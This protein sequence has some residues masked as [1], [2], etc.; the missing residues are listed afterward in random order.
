[1]AVKFDKLKLLTSFPSWMF[2]TQSLG[3]KRPSFEIPTNF[4]YIRCAAL[5]INRYKSTFAVEFLWVD[6]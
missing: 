2:F 1:M 4:M 6:L 3:L 5:N